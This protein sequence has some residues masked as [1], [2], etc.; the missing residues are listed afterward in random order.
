M[1]DGGAQYV[2][3]GGSAVTTTVNSGGV[4]YVGTRGLAISTII[5]SGATQYVESG[6][7]ASDSTV[8]SGGYEFLSSGGTA[9]GTAVNSGGYEVIF[10]GGTATDTTLNSGGTIDVR[11]LPYVKGGSASVNALTDV[12][13]VSEGLQIYSQKLSGNYAL[14]SFLISDDGAG[15]TDIRIGSPAPSGLSFTVAADKGAAGDTF[16]VAGHGG[17]G[18]RVTLY[19]SATAIGT[20][21]VAASGAWSITTAKPLAIGAHSLSAREMDVVGNASPPSSSQSIRVNNMTPFNQV[22]FTGTAGKD[23]FTGGAG[24]DIFEFSTVNLANA[25]IAKGGGGTNYLVMTTPGTVNAGGVSGVEIYELGN[26]AADS[27]TL[28]NANFAGV[29]GSSILV[30]GGN[31]GNTVNAAALTG[32][33]RII[34]V[35]GA[36]KDV[37]TGGAGNDYFYFSAANLASTDT[38]AGGGGTN[39]LV[40]TTAGT[41]DAGGVS[42][43]E[44]YYLANGGA[45]SLTLA[46]A[47]FTG[48][49]GSSITI[50]G[51]NDG[52]TIN[53]SALT[54]ANRVIAV[55]GAGKDVFTGGAGNDYFYF[56][57]ANL[58]NTDIVKGGGGTNTLVMTTAGTVDAG[59]VSGVEDYYLGNGGANSLTLANANFTGVT[60]SSITIYGGND[61][62]TINAAALTGANRVI[63]HAGAGADT[64]TGGAGNDVFYAGG[65]TKMTGGLGANEF[66]FSAAG[67]NTIADFAASATNEIAFSNAGFALGQSG[68]SATPK[69]LPTSLFT[70]DA[71][72]AFTAATQRFA[73]D[74]ANGDLYYSASGTTASEHLVATLTNHPTLAASHLFFIT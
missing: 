8:N 30:Y 35:G 10:S 20:A 3:S 58:A 54:G 1:I 67:K 59:G 62:N 52:N 49:T 64:L 18:D 61:G 27:L 5:A 2:D 33:N 44:Y 74:A 14:Y 47:N 70:S 71:T 50:Y 7:A 23:N 22:V 73:Y 19:D 28:A 55:G 43:V 31:D 26:D 40:M 13:T 69:A 48:V 65:D 53:A 46:N 32:A 38:V 36:G 68:A 17:V 66:A 6:A 72:G 41:V 63:V 57:A 9:S 51:G 25:D 60:G 37:F 16:T 21:A 24:N 29:T 4:Q 42:G 15:G 56:S 45:N 12:I 39:Y 11:Y 34:A